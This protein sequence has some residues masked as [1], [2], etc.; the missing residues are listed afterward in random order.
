VWI[1]TKRQQ[2]FALMV[3]NCWFASGQPNKRF[4]LNQ[5]RVRLL[6]MSANASWNV[7][8]FAFSKQSFRPVVALALV[9]HSYA[10]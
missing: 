8:L 6:L 9:N 10:A 4:A 7:S 1:Q 3:W 2:L 5:L